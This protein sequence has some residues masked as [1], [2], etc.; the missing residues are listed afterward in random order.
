GL[1]GVVEQR[2]HE[3][4]EDEEDDDEEADDGQFV[5][6]EDPQ[7][8]TAHVPDR[9]DLS[10]LG[11]GVYVGGG[12]DVAGRGWSDRPEEVLRPGR[13]SCL[14]RQSHEVLPNRI[15]GSAMA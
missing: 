7:D 12:N 9:R 5:L 2:A 6:N 4:E 10:A 11:N 3:A 14:V 8:L 15:R 13:R 1:I